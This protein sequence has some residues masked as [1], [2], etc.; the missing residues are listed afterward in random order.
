MASR[1]MEGKWGV[2][3]RGTEGERDTEVERERKRRREGE[4]ERENVHT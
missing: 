4:R 1:N 3:H 2:Q